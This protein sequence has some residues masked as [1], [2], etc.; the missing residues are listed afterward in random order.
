MNMHVV[1]YTGIYNRVY[2]CSVNTHA[3][4]ESIIL[5]IIHSSKNSFVL[6]YMHFRFNKFVCQNIYMCNR[7][8]I[9]TRGIAMNLDWMTN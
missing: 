9:T 1:Y 8:E 2:L 3:R 6:N 5:N 4:I 7:V